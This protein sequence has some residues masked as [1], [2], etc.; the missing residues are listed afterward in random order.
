ML[1]SLLDPLFSPLL[2]LPSWLAIFLVSA[3][4][5]F[6]STLAYKYLTDQVRM[7]RLKKELKSYQEKL[8]V[9]SKDDPQK[10]MVVQ[11]EMMGK[12][13]ELMKQSFKPTLY[14]L[15]PLLIIFGWLNAHLAYEPLHP[16]VPFNVSVQMEKG[17]SGVV[18][19]QAA[20]SSLQVSTSTPASQSVVGGVASWTLKGSAGDYRL[21]FS[22]GN[23]S[24]SKEVIL[25]DETG[26]YAPPLEKVSSRPF[27]SVRLG[28][29]KIRPL[30]GLPLVGGFGWIGTYILMS[31]LLSILF[32]KLFGVV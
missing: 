29:E 14:T 8:K 30:A 23:V 21:T 32:R 27:V 6:F 25:T 1:S 20:P 7:K 24:F 13:M 17:F 18:S 2:V 19:L 22:S 31:M 12:N 3:V 15:L 11:K 10:A 5:S 16:G 26:V 4:I 28:N 9:L